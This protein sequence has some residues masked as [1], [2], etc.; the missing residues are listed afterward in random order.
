MAGA[1]TPSARTVVLEGSGFD[2][3]VAHGE[4]LR[5]L[6]AEAL[7]RWRESLAE[8]HGM[9]PEVFVAQFLAGTG[10]RDRVE[11]LSPDLAAEVRGIAAGAGREVDEIWAYNFM[12]EEWW[13]QPTAAEIGCSVVATPVASSAGRSTLL[14][15][16]MDLPA[17]MDGS[18][19]VLLVREPGVPDQVV[20]TA[21]GMIGLIG[22]NSA[23][24]GL[25]VNTLMQ[26]DRSADGLPVAF[27]VREVLRRETVAEAA[28]FLSTVPHASG[29]HYVV[30]DGSHVRAFECSARGR[31]EGPA[32]DEVLHTNHP[33]WSTHLR[34]PDPTDASA[35]PR[36]ANSAARFAALEAGMAGV[37]S[38]RSARE[39][40]AESDSGLYMVPSPEAPTSTFL[41][42][43]YI[44]TAPPEVHVTL[45]RPDTAS[46]EPISWETAVA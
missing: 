45:G 40:L 8:R 14:A 23:G 42:V 33:L 7:D 34:G 18:Q 2:R 24:L 11:Q 15:Q 10:H 5:P 9:A 32:S 25:C 22:A 43:E 26:L 21:A 17:W 36:A 16:N 29:Q 3:G 1:T 19:A 46:W 13:F 12:D 39:L 38:R 35:Q 44:L 37:R 4:A 41:S 27:V 31:V 20:A 6:I 28:A 30:A